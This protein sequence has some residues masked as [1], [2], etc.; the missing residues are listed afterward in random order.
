MLWVSMLSHHMSMVNNEYDKCTFQ[1]K[2][3]SISRLIGK[4]EQWIEHVTLKVSQSHTKSEL[5]CF[6]TV[7]L[8]IYT[9]TGKFDS[10]I[11]D[12]S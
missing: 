2:L 1:A 12:S 3:I 8:Y 5:N 4:L 7:C 9:Q 10:S 6:N 11:F